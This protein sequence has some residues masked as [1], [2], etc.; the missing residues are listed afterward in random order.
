MLLSMWTYPWDVLDIGLDTVAAELRDRARANGISLATSYHAGHFLQPRSPRRKSWF[1][2]DGTIYFQPTA[3]RW[4]GV[5]IRPKVADLTTDG[6]DVLRDLV[7]KR[8]RTGLTVQCWTVCLHN[9]RLGMLHPH[10]CTRN[11]FGDPN[12]F[13]LCPSNP[14]ARAYAT[15][16]V[17]DLTASYKPDVVELETIGFMGFNHGYHHEKDGVGLMPEDDFLLSLCFCDSCL[18]RAAAAGVDGAAAQ[19]TVRA[20]IVEA[21]DRAVP[22]PRWPD[23]SSRGPDLFAAA[24]EV[25]SYVRWRFEPVTSLAADIRAAADPASQIHVLDIDDGWL[26]GCDLAA[27]AAAT[28]GITLCVYDR[29][30]E[31]VAAGVAKAHAAM[32]AGKSL[33]AGLKLYWPEV[34]SAEDVAARAKAAVT[35]GATGINFYNYGLI[36]AA[37]LDWVGAA[38]DAVRA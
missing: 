6:G 11:A 28:D 33:R 14:D 7:R 18:A 36:P 1:P 23:F 38:S 17:A 30:P 26:S 8:D 34:T 10:A 35:S 3:A 22:A 24:P 25:E 32:P 19:R 16:L 31:A 9:T 37:R 2:E 15:T 21:C 29:P 12:Y 20:W 4:E 13:S 27:Q 5:T